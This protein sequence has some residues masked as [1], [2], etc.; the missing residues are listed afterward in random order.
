[1]GR[2]HTYSFLLARL[3]QKW[4]LLKGAI[5][6]IDLENNFYVVRFVLEED[7]RYVFSGGPWVIAGQSLVMQ[8]WKPGFDPNEA[9]ITCMA[10]WVHVTGLHVEWF[11]P[12]A[13]K[14]I[15]DL[16]GVT[17]RIDTHTIAQA[18]G[19]YARICIELDLTKPLIANVQVE[20]NWYAI[21]YEG[22][23]LVCFG[24]GIYGHNRNQCP[25]EIRVH[26][27]T[28]KPMEGESTSDKEPFRVD[29]DI[30][31]S[32]GTKDAYAATPA[33]SSHFGPWSLEPTHVDGKIN[34]AKQKSGS[35]FDPL[36]SQNEINGLPEALEVQ[37][38]VA[39]PQPCFLEPA[40]AEAKQI[41][42]TTKQVKGKQKA[43]G[44]P[45]K[46]LGDISNNG[47][48]KDA[49]T[50]TPKN[51]QVDF[52][53][54]VLKKTSLS[55]GFQVCNLDIQEETL[56]GLSFNLNKYLKEKGIGGDHVNKPDIEGHDPLILIKIL[57]Q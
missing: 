54:H 29:T 44:R 5:R 10:V 57:I 26:E 37:P 36:H 52:K 8:R 55:N 9:T 28:Q 23:H 32:S 22:L 30:G 13:I 21:E 7:M 19:K 47:K 20:N 38:P 27:D 1:M 16:I 25:S 42:E 43:K 51:R 18:R 40:C 35:R 53:P 45:R 56:D 33:D 50:N 17:Y 31:I 3:R 24:C 11:N 6:L 12:E 46:T 34:A 41:G 39:T 48:E 4:S 49:A 15:G 2:T 14:R